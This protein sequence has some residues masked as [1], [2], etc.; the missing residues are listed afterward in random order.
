MIGENDAARVSGMWLDLEKL[1]LKFDSPVGNN[2]K[3]FSNFFLF[4]CWCLIFCVVCALFFPFCVIIAVASCSVT[5]LLF[6]I[7]NSLRWCVCVC[8]PC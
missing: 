7:C 1:K 8:V 5:L 6:V 4:L 2:R 3:I